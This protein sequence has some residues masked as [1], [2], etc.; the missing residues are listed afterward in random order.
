MNCTIL[1]MIVASSALLFATPPTLPRPTKKEIEDLKRNAPAPQTGTAIVETVYVASSDGFS[2]VSYL[3]TW[4]GQKAIIEDPIR[5]TDYK[6]GDK[7][8][9]LIMKH[10]MSSKR[11]PKGKKLLHLQVLPYVPAP[12]PE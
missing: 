5:S 6:V 3:V 1:A 8:A 10:D 7:I 11:E 4:N 9:F 2:C 12:E